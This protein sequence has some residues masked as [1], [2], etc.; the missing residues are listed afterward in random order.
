MSVC[1]ERLVARLDRARARLGQRFRSLVFDRGQQLFCLVV[2]EL[3]ASLVSR[4]FELILL[5]S[6]KMLAFL[7]KL[8]LLEQYV[9]QVARDSGVNFDFIDCL[10]PPDKVF[11][12]GDRLVLGLDCADRNHSRCLLL[13]R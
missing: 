3:P 11:G 4:G 6:I 10:D 2:G 7:D 8:T 5:K 12:F 13:G 9:L 1:S